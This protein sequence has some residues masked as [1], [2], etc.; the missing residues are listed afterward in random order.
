MRNQKMDKVFSLS[1]LSQFPSTNPSQ[2]QHPQD[3]EHKIKAKLWNLELHFLNLQSFLQSQENLSLNRNNDILSLPL[4]HFQKC[5]G[6][7]PKQ[8]CLN[9]LL[10]VCIW[11]K[12]QLKLLMLQ[13]HQLI[14][15][16]QRDHCQ[17]QDDPNQIILILPLY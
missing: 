12:N 16:K 2:D 6:D 9:K 15:K 14:N 1:Q 8:G 3:Y 4:F 13:H 10:M 5:E 17:H 11:L 7:L